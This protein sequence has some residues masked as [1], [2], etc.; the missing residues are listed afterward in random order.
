L[1]L[2]VFTSCKKVP[3]IYGTRFCITKIQY[4]FL[5]IKFLEKI[6]KK[7]DQSQN[8][9]RSKKKIFIMSRLPG[10]GSL[11]SGIPNFA[12]FARTNSNNNATTTQPPPVNS[13]ATSSRRSSLANNNN[14][15]NNISTVSSSA[16]P[17]ISHI[18][19]TQQQQHHHHHHTHSHVG[20]PGI[21]ASSVSLRGVS[22]DTHSLQ[23]QQQ[24]GA[25][26]GDII[27]RAHA[28]WSFVSLLFSEWSLKIIVRCPIRST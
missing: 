11:G 23:Q 25:G 5:Q 8:T 3:L 13:S 20:I 22:T 21:S 19:V 7:K 16:T 18:N 28:T 27:M 10:F 17:E 4:L 9:L 6:H 15:N 14:N 2:K 26:G 24:Q 12:E 1:I